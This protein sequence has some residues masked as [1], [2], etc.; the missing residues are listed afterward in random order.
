[1]KIE[2]TTNIGVLGKRG[3]IVT[4]GANLGT[5][6]I[7]R[8]QAKPFMPI[9]KVGES[10]D[11]DEYKLF[12]DMTVKELQKVAKEKGVSY[13]GLKKADLIKELKDTVE[14]KEDKIEYKTK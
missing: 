10:K 5:G 13:A 3:D 7:R 14:T 9:G 11:W 1:M 4:V 8:R 6:L 12:D 2:L